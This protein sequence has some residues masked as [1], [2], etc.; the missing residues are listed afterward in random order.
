MANPNSATQTAASTAAVDEAVRV[1]AEA[2]RRS[3]ETAQAAL[4]ASRQYFDL[5][6][7]L[8]RDLVG[9][10]SA[11]AEANLQ[12]AFDAQNA[13]LVTGKSAIDSWTSLTNDAFRR[14]A[15]LAREA[16]SVTLKSYQAGNKLFQSLTV[17]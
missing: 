1:A 2:S 7:K 8:N 11:S 13:A 15:D 5:G 16:Q 14:W 17:G 12:T 4:Q 3:T 10:W 6:V 9:L